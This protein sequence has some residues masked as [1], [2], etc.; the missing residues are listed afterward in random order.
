MAP[1]VSSVDPLAVEQA[2]E[3]TSLWLLANW[4]ACLA[5]MQKL[6][7]TFGGDIKV[8]KVVVT[9]CARILTKQNS[10]MRANASGT[11]WISQVQHNLA[12]AEHYVNPKSCVDKLIKQL[13]SLEVSAVTL[14][15][16]AFHAC[17]W[18]IALRAAPA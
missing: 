12:V 15:T 8:T 5:T 11:N 9:L 13:Q 7:G 16:R 2:T 4:E 14:V 3:S 6:D 10:C 18:R 1:L 17:L